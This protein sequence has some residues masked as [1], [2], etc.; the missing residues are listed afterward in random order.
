MAHNHITQCSRLGVEQRLDVSSRGRKR[1]QK[2]LLFS[3]NLRAE[4]SQDGRLQLGAPGWTA[5]AT[6][7]FV[8]STQFLTRAGIGP[9]LHGYPMQ[10]QRHSSPRRARQRSS[11]RPVYRSSTMGHNPRPDALQRRNASKEFWPA[12]AQRLSAP[13][14]RG[15]FVPRQNGSFRGD[16]WS[17][18]ECRFRMVC[19]RT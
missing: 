2:F 15:F 9:S 7:S 19:G 13:L 16:L 8:V 12:R 10:V 11:P 5:E 3:D 6:Q 1:D 4:R 18:G 17:S 14:R